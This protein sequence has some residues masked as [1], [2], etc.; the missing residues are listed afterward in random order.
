MKGLRL[1]KARKAVVFTYMEPVSAAIFGFLALGQQLTLQTLT[2]GLMIV[3]A[4]YLVG[5]R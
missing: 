2:G 3:S 5:S 1:I 4:G